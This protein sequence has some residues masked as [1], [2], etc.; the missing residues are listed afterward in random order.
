MSD[1]ARHKKGSKKKSKHK[2]GD[3]LFDLSLEDLTNY[4]VGGTVMTR[5]RKKKKKAKK[6]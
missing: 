3:D 1:H 6:K 4:D 5:T 2:K